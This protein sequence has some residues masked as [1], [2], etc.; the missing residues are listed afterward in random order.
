MRT[1]QIPEP[2]WATPANWFTLEADSLTDLE[3]EDLVHSYRRLI[4][5]ELACADC[6]RPNPELVKVRRWAEWCIGQRLGDGITPSSALAHLTP[7]QQRA[8]RS[9]GELDGDVLFDHL[10]RGGLDDVTRAECLRVV[11]RAVA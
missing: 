8:C 10:R 4:G 5:A 2:V 3:D 9:V 7:N 1:V 11:D 6:G